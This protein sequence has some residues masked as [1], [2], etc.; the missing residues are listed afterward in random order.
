MPN[1]A[2]AEFWCGQDAFDVV[3]LEY[4]NSNND[5]APLKQFVNRIDANKEL[6]KKQRLIVV[7]LPVR[8]PMRASHGVNILHDWHGKEY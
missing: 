4:I 8:L 5:A 6:S 2:L 1:V 3:N 7:V